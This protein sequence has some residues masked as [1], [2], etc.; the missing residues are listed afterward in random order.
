[1]RLV[2]IMI[3]LFSTSMTYAQEE[4][5]SKE[6][7]VKEQV[8]KSKEELK[9][10]EKIKESSA[11]NRGNEDAEAIA[12]EAAEIQRMLD[13]KERLLEEENQKNKKG[14]KEEIR[15]EKDGQEG[16]E[17]VKDPNFGRSESEVEK[18]KEMTDVEIKAINDPKEK[19]ITKKIQVNEML[20]DKRIQ[21]EESQK[22]LDAFK[23][24]FEEDKAA[25]K[26]SKEDI[27]KRENLIKKIEESIVEL[28]REIK[29]CSYQVNGN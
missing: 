23:K 29:A 14:K 6:D 4:K 7:L 17:T 26:L 19:L 2:L 12:K 20:D 24:S 8:E 21:I 1:M 25:N 16:K 22:K 18:I 5:K 10:K 3:L 27:E 28:E 9:N 11:S 15:K 13:E